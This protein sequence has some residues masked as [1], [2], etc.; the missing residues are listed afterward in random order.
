MSIRVLQIKARNKSQHRIQNSKKLYTQTSN[1]MGALS[2]CGSSKKRNIQPQ[3]SQSVRLERANRGIGIMGGRVLNSSAKLTH[4][5]IPNP[6][7]ISSTSYIEK[8]KLRASAQ[9]D[10]DNATE[11][12]CANNSNSSNN[13]GKC[14]ERPNC[15]RR[16]KTNITK[17]IG[18]MSYSDYMKRFTAKKVDNLICP[19]KSKDAAYGNSNSKRCS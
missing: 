19:D 18:T 1:K 2:Q 16:M 13:S 12:E 15:R 14:V 5:K 8:L 7:E 17:K 4:K 3:L 10:K 9:D 11:G 6:D